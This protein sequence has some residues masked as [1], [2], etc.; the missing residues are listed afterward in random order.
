MG[1]PNPSLAMG[2]L[3]PS[4]PSSA[5]VLQG[6]SEPQEEQDKPRNKSCPLGTR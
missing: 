1:E 6:S 2:D 5:L 4:L 3:N